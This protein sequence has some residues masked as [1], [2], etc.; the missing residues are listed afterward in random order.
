MSANATSELESS[1]T[2]AAQ[3]YT[4]HVEPADQGG[5]TYIRCRGCGREV[6]GTNF[7]RL[8]HRDGCE[9]GGRQ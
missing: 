8:P 3:P 5:E 7:E 4:R 2:T 6:I 9:H 1:D